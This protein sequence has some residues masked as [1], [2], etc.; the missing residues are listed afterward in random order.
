MARIRPRGTAAK[1]NPDLN[2]PGS[3]GVSRLSVRPLRANVTACPGPLPRPRIAQTRQTFQLAW[4]VCAASPRLGGYWQNVV[5]GGM[6]HISSW[7]LILQS[8]ALFAKNIRFLVF[9]DLGF[10][11]LKVGLY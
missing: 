8:L 4:V 10:I 3:V 5:G 9:G 1:V 11:Q 7:M 6:W 2:I